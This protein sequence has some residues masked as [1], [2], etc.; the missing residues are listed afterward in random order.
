MLKLGSS[1]PFNMGMLFL[2]WRELGMGKFPHSWLSSHSEKEFPHS[3]ASPL[4]GKYSFTIPAKPF[5]WKFFFP[6]SWLHH[7]GQENPIPISL[8]MRSRSF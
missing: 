4:M 5:M 6:P 7:L 8:Q 2:I 3:A 1:F